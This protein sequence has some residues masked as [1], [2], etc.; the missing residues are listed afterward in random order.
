MFLGTL[1]LH[2]TTKTAYN[3]ILYNLK[4]KVPYVYYFL[5]LYKKE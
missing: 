1:F 3:Q 5:V 2:K 4:S